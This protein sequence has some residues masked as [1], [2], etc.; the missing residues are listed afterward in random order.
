MKY[1]A[2]TRE[3]ALRKAEALRRLAAKTPFAAEKASALRKAIVIEQEYGVGP[4]PQAPDIYKYKVFIRRVSSRFFKQCMNSLDHICA[5]SNYACEITWH[6]EKLP[7]IF[8]F[9]PNRFRL[10]IQFSSTLPNVPFLVARRFK[11]IMG[12]QSVTALN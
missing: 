4:E 2:L 7:R 6:A 3:N 1:S 12:L 9:M 5:T 11:E 10:E 8:F